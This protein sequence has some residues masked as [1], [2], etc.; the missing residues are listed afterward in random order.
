MKLIISML[1]AVFALIP[2][3]HATESKDIVIGMAIA[4]SGWIEAYDNNSVKMVQLWVDETNAAGGILGRKL[5]LET[6][7]TKSDRAEGAKA[8]QQLVSDG[9]SIIFVSGDYDF[10]APAALQAQK[11]G[12][13]SAFLGASDPKAGVLGVGALSFTTGLAGQVEGAS[14]AEWGHVQRHYKTGYVLLDDSIQYDK[15]VCAGYDW[16]F[17]R[18]GGQI[19][20]SDSFKNSD[21]LINSQVTRLADAIRTTGVDHIMLCSYTPGGASAVKQIRAAGI[22]LPILSATAMDGTYWLG[23]V[24]GLKDFYVPVQALPQ[25]DPRPAVTALTARYQAKYHELPTTQYAYLAYPFLQL[26]A[27]AVQSTGTFD[28]AKVVA[29]L[30]TYHDVDTVLGPRSFSKQLHIQ[31]QVPMII[32]ETAGDK[33]RVVGNSRISQ[34]IPTDVLYNLSR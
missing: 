1:A 26:W 27:K 9:A 12:I 32:T 29:Q 24:G 20:G 31:T 17:K 21:P 15:S 10:G 8:G 30:E 34:A 16:D 28:S 6:V 3:A 25:G 5:R 13:I 14:L 23:S 2:T 19:A 33:Q 22:N 18:L 7:D 4:R 11:A